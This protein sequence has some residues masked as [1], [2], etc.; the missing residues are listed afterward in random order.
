MDVRTRRFYV[1]EISST[2]E[3]VVRSSFQRYLQSPQRRRKR[4][5]DPVVVSF[6]WSSLTDRR[7]Q[8]RTVILRNNLVKIHVSLMCTVRR[9]LNDVIEVSNLIIDSE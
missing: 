8:L 6:T 5:D 1:K 4:L 2:R 7:L 3:D 9:R